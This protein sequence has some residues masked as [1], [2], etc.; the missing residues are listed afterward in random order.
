[1][2]KNQVTIKIS[3]ENAA[4]HEISPMHE[5]SRILSDI[6][7]NCQTWQLG[8]REERCLLDINGNKVGKIVIV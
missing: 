5:V 7:D 8:R 1:M 3:T 4:F 6:A 2:V